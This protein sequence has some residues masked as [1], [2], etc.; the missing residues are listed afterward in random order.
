MSS[1]NNYVSY[2]FNARVVLILENGKVK[3]KFWDYGWKLLRGGS[4]LIAQILG[5][6]PEFRPEYTSTFPKMVYNT[7]ARNWG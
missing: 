3:P 4:A 6:G 2:V 5:Y 7:P 1:K